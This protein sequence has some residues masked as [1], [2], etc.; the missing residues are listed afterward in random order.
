MARKGGKGQRWWTTG[1]DGHF[2]ILKDCWLL[3]ANRQAMWTQDSYDACV[4]S[5][6]RFAG[7]PSVLQLAAYE[8]HGTGIVTSKH[9]FYEQP[10]F[11]SL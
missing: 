7:D 8:I 11:D 1:D 3:M 9:I 4:A 6:K 2:E 10:R 5:A